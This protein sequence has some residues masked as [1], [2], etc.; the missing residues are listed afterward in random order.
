MAGSQFAFHSSNAVQM[1]NQPAVSALRLD[2]RI[3]QIARYFQDSLEPAVGYLE[4]VI[5]PS[6]ADNRVTPHTADDQ[7]VFGDQHLHVI[8]F[9]ARKIEFDRPPVRTFV[10]VNRRLPQRPARPSILCAYALD[11]N[12]LAS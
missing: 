6:F 10:N 1:Q 5:A 11:K 12:S 7:F 4:L 9:D 3:R 2:F 8:K